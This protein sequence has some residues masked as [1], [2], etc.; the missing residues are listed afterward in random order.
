[1]LGKLVRP[2]WEFAKDASTRHSCLRN[3][4]DGRSTPGPSWGYLKSQFPAGLSPSGDNFPQKRPNGSK[5]I[6]RKTP[7]RAFCCWGYNPKENHPGHPT[8]GCI[9]IEG[10]GAEGAPEGTSRTSLNVIQSSPSRVGVPLPGR[11]P[12]PSV[13]VPLLKSEFPS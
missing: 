9:P 13:G 12:P 3:A 8:R 4:G 10:E 2:L 1:V 7:R 5:Y 6:Q 11:N